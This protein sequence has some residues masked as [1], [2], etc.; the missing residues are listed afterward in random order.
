MNAIHRRGACPALAAPMPTGDGLLVRLNTVAGGFSPSQLIGLC[1]AAL[2]H[3]NGVV[4]VT[5]RGSFQIRGLNEASAQILATEVDAL[6]IVVRTGVLVETGPLAGLDPGEVADPRPLAEMIS[7]AVASASLA[8]RLGPKVSVVVDGGGCPGM[9]GVAA[10]IRLT[11]ER[12]GSEGSVATVWC[13]AI[14]GDAATATP[15][16]RFD[17]HSAAAAVSALLYAVAEVGIG[18]RARDL[19]AERVSRIVRAAQALHTVP[20]P[21]VLPDLSPATGEG[22]GKECDGARRDRDLHPASPA[23]PVASH[24]P[25]FTP[26]PLT[27]SRHAISIALPYGS[28]EAALLVQLVGAANTLDIAEI[29]L[30]PQ[31]RLIFIAPTEAA[32]FA[33]R[34]HAA[35]LGFITETR[36]PRL[37]IS[38]CPGSPAC[39]SGHL[40][41][42]EVAHALAGAA[43]DALDG[44]LSLHISG[45][46]KGCAHPA[47]ASLTLVGGEN[48]AGLVVGG[49]AAAPPIAYA[50]KVEVARRLGAAL[51]LVGQ[52]RR[53]R[54]TSAACAARLGADQ[55]ASAF[56]QG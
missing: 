51:A 34:Q 13:L 47:P 26:L 21:S 1:E 6:G 24:N 22:G 12:L 52:S 17:E 5:A 50:G 14:A 36:D 31:R 35:A 19:T 45:C 10:D 37:A 8:T 7:N 27:D 38:S 20:P 25:P 30:A 23:R 56:Q 18:A 16:A 32:C 46:T 48:G 3:G 43:A 40:A 29:R 44:S 39:G 53:S 15:A 9:G 2:R 4:E 28:T 49:T 41:A 54:E 33:I 55:L 42:R 11:A